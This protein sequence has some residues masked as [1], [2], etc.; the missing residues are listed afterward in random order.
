MQRGCGPV[1]IVVSEAYLM[2]VLLCQTTHLERC[3][4]RWVSRAFRKG[5]HS[6]QLPKSRILGKP[7]TRIFRC[8]SPSEPTHQGGGFSLCSSL[9]TP[10]FL[11]PVLR[12]SSYLRSVAHSLSI[13]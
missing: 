9:Q 4:A 5:I 13:G 11:K 6:P 8:C 10:H 12:S 3:H 2:E 1:S 7:N